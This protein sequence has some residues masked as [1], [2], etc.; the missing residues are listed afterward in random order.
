MKKLSAILI[1]AF[2][3]LGVATKASNLTASTPY[4]SNQQRQ[5]SNFTGIEIGGSINAFVKLGNTES[6]RLEGDQEAI[7][8]LITEVTNGVLTIKPK[9]KWNDWFKKFRNAK[10]T[11]YITAKKITSLGLSGS[12]SIDV[13]GTINSSSLSIALSGSGNI[14]ASANVTNFDG[15]ISGS[16][17]LSI[18]GKAKESEIRISGSGTFS[19]KS[20][21]VETLSA[22]VSGSGNVSIDA[23]QSIN[24]S[25]SGS[26]NISYSGDPKIQKS[27]SGSG[28]VRKI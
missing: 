17:G 14:K 11:A 26:G 20:F 15:A 25:I 12:G 10:I 3:A 28:S 4:Y 21:S 23:Q 1:L 2:L 7:D 27:V 5:V 18:N 6:L 19:G 24:A 8:N 16:G 22:H 9:T 13:D